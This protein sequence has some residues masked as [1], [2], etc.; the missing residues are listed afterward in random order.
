MAN[1]FNVQEPQLTGDY[2]FKKR[3]KNFSKPM[4]RPKFKIKII[5]R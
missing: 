1:K 4:Y 3:F 5:D 2:N